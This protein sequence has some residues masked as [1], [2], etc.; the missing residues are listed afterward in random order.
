MTVSRT[1]AGWS[2]CAALL[3]G[4]GGHARPEAGTTAS[5]SPSA[6]R[7]P[8]SSGLRPERLRDALVD[9]FG[10]ATL[11]RARKAT[12]TFGEP[13][14]W[15]TY[16]SLD[17]ESAASIRIT[18]PNATGPSD[19]SDR[20]QTPPRP[21]RRSVFVRTTAGRVGNCWWR[22]RLPPSPPS[23]GT[24]SRPDATA[25]A[26]PA[27]RR[28]RRTVPSPGRAGG[29]VARPSGLP[30]PRETGR[31]PSPA[32][33]SSPPATAA[34]WARPTSPLRPAPGPAG[35]PWHWPTPPTGKRG[36]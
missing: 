33:C 31:P 29:R 6:A 20:P 19:R 24:G 27:S 10:N 14:A 8:T 5:A 12:I 11:D 28:P 1:V 9:R 7:S 32:R 15:G 25:S 13:L 23:S 21:R 36:D 35:R 17:H 16:G 30:G 18:P 34:C 26:W 4:C 2:V 22:P 3:S